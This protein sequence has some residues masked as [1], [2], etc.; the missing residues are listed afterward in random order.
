MYTLA[1]KNMVQQT[2]AFRLPKEECPT[3]RLLVGHYI[4]W[5]HLEV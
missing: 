1:H 2:Q 4:S 5:V 3:L